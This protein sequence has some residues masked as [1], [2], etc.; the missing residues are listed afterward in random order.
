MSR[1]GALLEPLPS[2]REE[3]TLHV[4]PQAADGSPTWTLH[5]PVNNRFFQIGWQEFEVLSRWSL[6]TPTRIAAAIGAA[7]TWH[8]APA[9]VMRLVER[10][11]QS[12]LL[13]PR[14]SLDR[15]RL[16]GTQRALQGNRLGWLLHHY[17]SL[18]IPL[19]HPEP[20]LRRTMPVVQGMFSGWFFT[21]VTLAAGLGMLLISRQW[22]RFTG[23]FLHFFNLTGMFYYAGALTLSKV[24]HELGHAYAAHRYGCRV[25]T[26]GVIFLVLWPRLYT[27]TSEVWKLSARRQRLVVGAAGMLA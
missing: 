22:E 2:L 18:R 20:F 21:L 19:W 24:L 23:S 8:P 10:L 12:H 6:A 4:G 13:V 7:T 9:E 11:W 15:A 1:P 3:L 5:D 26:M 16:L 17:L 27:D 14:S 25:S